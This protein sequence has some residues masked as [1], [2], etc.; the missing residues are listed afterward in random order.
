MVVELLEPGGDLPRL[1]RTVILAPMALVAGGVPGLLLARWMV[2]AD[3]AEVATVLS[4]LA[5]GLVAALLAAAVM[6]AADPQLP[7]QIIGRVRRPA[8][9]PTPPEQAEPEPGPPEP[10]TPEPGPAAEARPPAEDEQ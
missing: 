10:E 8:P 1:R 5:A 6:V 4:G 2:R 9:A 7:R 3:S